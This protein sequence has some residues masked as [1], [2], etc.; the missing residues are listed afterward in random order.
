MLMKNINIL[1]CFLLFLLIIGC[2]SDDKG[3][4]RK[5]HPQDEVMKVEDKIIDIETDILFSGA[6]SVYILDNYFIV[7]EIKPSNNKAI[8]IFNKNS[9]KYITSTGVI[10]KGPGEI[11]RPGYI[12]IDRKNKILWVLDSG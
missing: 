1:G 4:T 7:G 11:N 9:F 2:K 12:G 8:H 6:S 5:F 10:G 3:K